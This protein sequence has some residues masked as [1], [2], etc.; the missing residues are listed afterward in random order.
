MDLTPTIAGYPVRLVDGSVVK[1]PGKTGS[2]WRLHYS[3]RLPSLECEE[4]ILTP[5]HGTGNGDCLGPP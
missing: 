3:L 2:Q 1:E 5:A 4:F